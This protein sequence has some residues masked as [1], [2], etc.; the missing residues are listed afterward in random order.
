MGS[1]GPG[2]QRLKRRG[3]SL[4]PHCVV[5]AEFLMWSRYKLREMVAGWYTRP[6]V[7]TDSG[8][9]EV[10]WKNEM[11]QATRKGRDA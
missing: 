2:T 4:P 11:P 3:S 7:F 8:S 9:G 1:D 5:K 10:T 6:R